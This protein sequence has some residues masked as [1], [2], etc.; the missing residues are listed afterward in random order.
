MKFI[1]TLSL[2]LCALFALGQSS[3]KVLTFDKT[4]NKASFTYGGQHKIITMEFDSEGNLFIF[5]EFNEEINLSIN[6]NNPVILSAWQD[7]NQYESGVS[8]FIAKYN[9]NFELLGY[10]QI[11]IYP[12][13]RGNQIDW[14][15]TIGTGLAKFSKTGNLFITTESFSDLD[16]LYLSR[17]KKILAPNAN[18]HILKFKTNCELDWIKKLPDDLY[19]SYLDVK[20]NPNE[21]ILSG[22]QSGNADFNPNVNS[23]YKIPNY[24]PNLSRYVPTAF[25]SIYDWSFNFKKA[26][27]LSKNWSTGYALDNKNGG[28]YFIVNAAVGADIIPKDSSGYTNINITDGLVVDENTDII[29]NLGN[30]LSVKKGLI[31]SQDINWDNGSSFCPA[32]VDNSGKLYVPFYYEKDSV[33]FFHRDNPKNRLILSPNTIR[34]T[35]NIGIACFDSLHYAN[36]FDNIQWINTYGGYNQYMSINDLEIDDNNNVWF[37]GNGSDEIGKDEYEYWSVDFNPDP[38]SSNYVAYY[39]GNITN[40]DYT[41]QNYKYKEGYSNYIC[42]VDS[43]GKLDFIGGIYSPNGSSS[44]TDIASG[45]NTIVYGGNLIGSSWFNSPSKGARIDRSINGYTRPLIPVNVDSKDGSVIYIAKYKD[46]K[47]TTL[48]TIKRE[49]SKFKIYPNPA[50]NMITI[51]PISNINKLLSSYQIID[52]NGRFIQSGNING[53]QISL[54]PRIKSGTYIIQ[55]MA[56]NN[57][58]YGSST[59]I[60][61]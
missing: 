1:I 9:S 5:G 47:A 56:T 53:N 50:V 13:S 8:L 32:K 44:I 42:K 57:E 2:F 15:G 28:Y 17:D 19:L 4:D 30:D 43:K 18:Q 41:A 10:N 55:I 34:N 12:N 59:L 49:P 37:S 36:T 21:I 20:D 58:L 45:P 14:Y 39:S 33:Y 48:S 22:Q 23:E 51:K 6:E 61:D 11:Q 3:S 25:I 27:S 7:T 38:D 24:R 40:C 54:K 31:T 46:F 26:A 29:F 52:I 60:I 35:R 16:T